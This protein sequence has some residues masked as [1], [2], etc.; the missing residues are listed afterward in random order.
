MSTAKVIVGVLAGVAVGAAI[1]ILFSP[2]KGINTRKKITR[3][4]EDMMHDIE[5]GL[6][7]MYDTISRKYGQATEE[8]ER[9]MKSGKAKLNKAAE[10]LETETK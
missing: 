10:K 5:D 4:S 7:E 2:D 8:V 1:G 9:V 6:S 3:K